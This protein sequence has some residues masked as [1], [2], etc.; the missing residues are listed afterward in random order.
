MGHCLGDAGEGGPGALARTGRRGHARRVPDLDDVRRLALALPETDEH[1]S[2]GGSQAWRVRGRASIWERPLS[3]FERA[4]LG[5]AAPAG[6]LVGVRVADLGVK[7]ALLADGPHALLTRPHFDGSP[8]V[9]VRL[10]QAAATELAELVVDAW[11]VRA[12]QRLAAALRAERRGYPGEGDGEAPVGRL[13]R[14]GPAS[15]L[16]SSAPLS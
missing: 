2:Y 3:R 13:V 6:P 11:L 15:G 1:P 7:E 12:P 9:L 4:A 16:T 10:D 5:A 8:V 14:I